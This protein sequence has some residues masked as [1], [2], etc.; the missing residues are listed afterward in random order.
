MLLLNTHQIWTNSI[1]T[2][3]CENVLK[4]MTL[5]V[6]DSVTDEAN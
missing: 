4:N 6:G 5:T 1:K 2:P 3:S